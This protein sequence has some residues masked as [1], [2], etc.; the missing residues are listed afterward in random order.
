[1]HQSFPTWNVIHQVIVHIPIILL[2]V[3]PILVIVSIGFPSAK[4]Q[5]FLGSALT[6]MVLG[7]A[8]SFLA[9]TTGEAAMRV[10]AS[11]P[12]LKVSMEEH[13]ALAETTTALFSML[14]LGFVALVFAPKLLGRE[15]E[16]RISTVLLAVYL[17]LYATGALFLIHTALQG[18][19][20]AHGLDVKSVAT[21]QLPGK[22]GAK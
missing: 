10:A 19:H 17:L 16:G 18:G 3:A 7:T 6:L 20:L 14:T 15:L 2:L 8:M 4:R 5:L 13:R 21:I 22:E 9:V 1:M 12:D 11:A